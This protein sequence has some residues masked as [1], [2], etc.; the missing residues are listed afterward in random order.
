LRAGT[1]F[2]IVGYDDIGEAALWHPALTT[3]FTRI[4]EYGAA[5]ADLVLARIADPTRPVERVVLTPR[6][7]VRASAG[8]PKPFPQKPLPRP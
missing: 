2:S 5:A 8:P 7:V 6:L 4:P 3:V 1:D